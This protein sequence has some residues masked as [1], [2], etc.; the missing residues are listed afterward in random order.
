M[1][2][3]KNRVQVGALHLW[4]MTDIVEFFFSSCVYPLLEKPQI[5]HK[6]TLLAVPR[7][8]YSVQIGSI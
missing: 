4:L 2:I 6:Y 7:T 5:S 3:P 1:L 8:A